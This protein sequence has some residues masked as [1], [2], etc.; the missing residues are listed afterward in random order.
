MSPMTQTVSVALATV[1]D[2]GFPQLAAFAERIRELGQAQTGF[3]SCT[4]WKDEDFPE[5]YALITDVEAQEDQTGLI[6]ASLID[7]E[8]LHRL[9]EGYANP[10]DLHV[11]RVSSRHGKTNGATAPGQTMSL[12][13]RRAEPGYGEDLEM[14]LRDIFES[15]KYIDGYVGSILGPNRALEEEIVAMAF[16]QTRRAFELSLPASGSFYEIRLFER[17]L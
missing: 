2:S 6:F 16:W 8:A 9:N 11:M 12:S 3:R 7:E 13:M 17:V 15:I 5:R 4:L 1:Q 10:A 14:E